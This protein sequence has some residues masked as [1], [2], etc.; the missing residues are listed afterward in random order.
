MMRR[1]GWVAMALVGSMGALVSEDV[2]SA[3]DGENPL[4]VTGSELVASEGSEAVSELVPE[5]VLVMPETVR[6]AATAPQTSPLQKPALEPWVG[7][8]V[9]APSQAVLAQL[10]GIP[11][12]VGFVIDS[13]SKGSPAEA[14]GLQSY[15]FLWK[16]EDQLLVNRSQFATLLSL[17]KV[18]ARVTLTILRGGK[19]EE[20]ELMIGARPECEKGRRR[21]DLAVMTPP[22]PGMST[23]VNVLHKTARL[24][25]EDGVI[26]VWRDGD[27]YGWIKL[28]EFGLEMSSGMLAGA[29]EEAFPPEQE[30]EL[31]GK[32][33]ALIRAYEQA[34][35]TR[36]DR[37]RVPRVRRVPSSDSATK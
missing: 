19:N 1:T 27:G 33:Q 11:K 8:H 36:E 23:I 7:V 35:R 16:M 5:A 34:A 20:I 26:K 15:D 17:Q 30:E 13:V 4:V 18:G 10:T 24:R 6:E 22:I 2:V 12:G 28:D 25:D 37:V 3:R 31:K 14:V 21:A 32:L 9:S 29:E